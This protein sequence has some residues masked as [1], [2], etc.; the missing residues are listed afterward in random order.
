V[1]AALEAGGLTPA[2]GGSG[3]LVALELVDVARDWDVTVD[4]Y[5]HEVVG[6]MD[7][8]GLVYRDDTVRDDLYATDVRFVVSV[9]G[10]EV[11]VLVGFALR[12]PAGKVER[13]Q[14]R[15]S[16]H[17]LGLPLVWAWAYRLLNRP[18][19]AEVLEQWLVR[20]RTGWPEQARSSSDPG[21]WDRD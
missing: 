2:I 9:A 4:A 12:S 1:I 8:A 10:H 21:I 7:Q 18:A 6:A 17:W 19:K 13:L 14:T 16:G 15:V 3:L 11:D 5:A 20:V